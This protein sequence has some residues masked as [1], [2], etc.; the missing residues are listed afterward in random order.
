MHCVPV[1]G[2]DRTLIQSAAMKVLDTPCFLWILDTAVAWKMSQTHARPCHQVHAQP[3]LHASWLHNH[4]TVSEGL[5]PF[6][7]GMDRSYTGKLAMYGEEV[8]GYLRTGLKAGPRW[9]HGVWLGKT[10]SG[11]QHT[12]GTSD[13]VFIT[14]SI[15]R[16]LNPFNLDR[17][18]D[19]ESWPWEF[20]HAASGNRLIYSKRVSQPLAFGIGSGMPP[21]IDLEA[22][23]VHKYAV[24]HPEEDVQQSAEAGDVPEPPPDLTVAASST[25]AAMDVSADPHGQKRADDETQEIHRREPDLLTKVFHC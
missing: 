17:L 3:L 10:I 16:T 21:S 24:E 9:Q 12:V 23:H 7:R 4:F 18:G 8:L 19:L 22:I 2:H 25:A 20:G 15:R 6:E 14:R 5:T 11:D 1:T 13:G